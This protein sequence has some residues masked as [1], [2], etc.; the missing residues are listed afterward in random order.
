MELADIFD[1]TNKGL[2]V[3]YSGANSLNY[4]Y[5][6]KHHKLERTVDEYDGTVEINF[7]SDQE[8]K[9]I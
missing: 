5:T 9:P 4:K 2:D 1:E 3:T 7:S 8:L 6:L